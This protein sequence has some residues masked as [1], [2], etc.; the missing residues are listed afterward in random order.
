MPILEPTGAM[1][2]DTLHS[3]VTN[4]SVLSPLDFAPGN[5]KVA[6]DSDKRALRMVTYN[7]LSLQ[8]PLQR[9]MLD[10]QFSQHGIDVMF[11]QEAR[12]EACA[13]FQA[14]ISLGPPVLLN[15]V[16]LGAK[17]GS[18]SPRAWAQAL[19]TDGHHR[20][21]RYSTLLPELCL[22]LA[23][24]AF[25]SAHGPTA[26]A[27]AHEID[28]WWRDMQA[29]L[30]KVPGRCILCIGC[31]AARFETGGK[32]PD[33]DDAT[34]PAGRHLCELMCQQ[35]LCSN[36]FFDCQGRQVC[37]WTSPNGQSACIDYVLV[38]KEMQASLRTVGRLEGFV[39]MY[40]FDRQPL[41]VEISWTKVL[42]AASSTAKINTRAI[43]TVEGRCKLQRIF[44][45][46]P[47]VDWK[48]DVDTHLLIV[49]R[50]LHNALTASFPAPLQRPRKTY[51][52]DETWAT[53]RLRRGQ[54]RIGAR[55]RALHARVLLHTLHASLEA[56]T[57]SHPASEQTALS[58]GPFGSYLPACCAATLSAVATHGED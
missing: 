15:G 45:Q 6:P 25:L 56:S 29:I 26:K 18:A 35:S 51:F 41:A 9:E 23:A 39:D 30:K 58:P 3:P 32:F 8:S 57:G 10:T 47:V 48:V 17:F 52:S 53:V 13:R 54:K 1:M 4:G 20:L 7:C 16:A 19:M 12:R 22:S 24:F 14:R 43:D 55:A 50:Y 33:I 2:D 36:S 28:T 46:A 49:N 21:C 31:D 5:H 44:S 42:P 38:P 11:L 37:T 40:E 34:G 27:P